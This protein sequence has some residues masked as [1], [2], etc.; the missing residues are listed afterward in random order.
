MVPGLARWGTS[1]DGVQV[2][3]TASGERVLSIPDFEA[4][5]GKRRR[6]AACHHDGVFD[7]KDDIAVYKAVG[8]PLVRLALEGETSWL[9]QEEQFERLGEDLALFA[10]VAF[11]LVLAFGLL[12]AVVVLVLSRKR[13]REDAQGSS[14]APSGVVA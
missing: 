5:D 2:L 13:R 8:A 10:S 7:D 14:E 12:I 6:V 11:G 4:T 9:T 3:T 1:G